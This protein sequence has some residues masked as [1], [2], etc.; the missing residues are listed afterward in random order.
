[1]FKTV[2]AGYN[3]VKCKRYFYVKFLNYT[4][5][6]INCRQV[7]IIVVEVYKAI[8]LLFVKLLFEFLKK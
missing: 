4:C 6:I 2:N 8:C 1:M 7:Y 3:T 5:I